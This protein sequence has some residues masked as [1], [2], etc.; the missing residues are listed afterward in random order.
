MNRFSGSYNL[1]S[2]VLLDSPQPSR[3]SDRDR[4]RDHCMVSL[5][6]LPRVVFVSELFCLLS[7]IESLILS[8]IESLKSDTKLFIRK[9]QKENCRDQVLQSDV[10][11]TGNGEPETVNREWESG[12]ECTA[13]IHKTIR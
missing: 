8:L 1:G 9:I 4:D 2:D 13:V 12:N 7:L 6:S 3:L 10:T 11:K 5:K